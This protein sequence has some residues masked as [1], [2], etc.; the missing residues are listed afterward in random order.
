MHVTQI[1]VDSTF[2]LHTTYLK[3]YLKI[4]LINNRI[5]YEPPCHRSESNT[6]MSNVK[7]SKNLTGNVHYAA[8]VSKLLLLQG[9]LAWFNAMIIN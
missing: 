9:S 5:Y 3:K 6:R 2:F 1:T 7:S 8:I 4:M